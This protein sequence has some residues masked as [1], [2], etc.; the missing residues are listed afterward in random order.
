MSLRRTLTDIA[1]RALAPEP[2]SRDATLRRME[3]FGAMTYLVSSAEYLARPS[4]RR[5]GGFN[6]WSVARR[7][8]LV[9]MP[10]AAR[11]V[12]FIA[13]PRVTEAVHVARIAAAAALL[14]P[15]RGRRRGIAGALL[16]LS[17][18]GLHQRHHNGTDGTDQVS[19]IVAASTALSRAL[20]PK[21]RLVDSVL[22]T[23]ALQATLSYAASGW[24]KLAGPSWRSGAAIP[25][26]TRTRTYGDPQMWRLVHRHPF[27]GRALGAN[28]LAMECLFP[29]IYLAR[30]RIAPAWLHGVSFFH[31]VNAR[32]M[33]LGRFVWA[34]SGLHPAILFATDARRRRSMKISGREEPARDDTVPQATALLGVAGVA[35]GLISQARRRTRV[36]AGREG[37]ERL[38]TSAGNELAFVRSGRRDDGPVVIFEHGLLSSPEFW[39]WTEQ[40]LAD[41]CE[42]VSYAR[43]GYSSS[44]YGKARTGWA[45][46]AGVDDL[47]ELARHVGDGRAVVLAGHSLGGWIALRAA[48]QAPDRVA[49]VV[50]VDSSHPAELQRSTRQAKGQEA[51]TQNLM[52]MGPSLALGLGPLLEKPEW[53]VHFPPELHK[54]ILDQ[55]RDPRMWTAGLREWRAVETEFEAFSEGEVPPVQCPVLAITAGL[56]AK[57]D[58]VQDELHREYA[59]LN[60]RSRHVVVDGADHERLLFDRRAA[61]TVAGHISEML[62]EIAEEVPHETATR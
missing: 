11:I 51:I 52:L 50:L 4:D 35:G 1:R 44:R 41:R 49:G 8:M 22:W 43:A 6:D 5:R 20:Q 37:E 18:L 23:V 32:V 57:L 14:A 55:Y 45:I 33:G 9:R 48:A 21:P 30:G 38:R 54:P 15:T 39:H 16:A 31:L 10:R 34:F 53:I 59:A 40:A 47:L 2:A 62:G 61:A 42:V 28:V 58:P 19:F 7:V 26:V 25:G 46:D 13:R 29:T 56:T 3:R 12:D 24:V 27:L 17:S 60:D 36:L